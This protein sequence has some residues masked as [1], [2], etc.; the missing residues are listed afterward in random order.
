[1]FTQATGSVTGARFA[2]KKLARKQFWKRAQIRAVK[3]QTTVGARRLRKPRIVFAGVCLSVLC[4]LTGRAQEV[5]A[6]PVE[7]ALATRSFNATQTGFSPDGKWLAY[8]VWEDQRTAAAFSG[9]RAQG[10][11]IYLFSVETGETRH[12]PGPTRASWAPSWSPDAHALAFLSDHD[13][14]TTAWIWDPAK[15]ES[16]ELSDRNVVGTTIEWTTDSRAVLLEVPC[17]DKSRS[18]SVD[19]PRHG[20][21]PEKSSAPTV[22]VYRAAAAAPGKE[23]PQSDPWKLNPALADLVL[24]DVA[25][26]NVHSIVE[27]RGIAMYRLSP[28]GSR[29]AFTSPKRFE[30]PGSQQVI[31]DLIVI[32][33]NGLQERVAAPDIPLDLLGD[34]SWSPDGRQ[35]A[36]ETNG[37]GYLAIDCYVVDAAGGEPRNITLFP[38]M[39]ETS[40]LNNMLRPRWG[41][42]GDCIYLIRNGEFWRAGL[43]GSKPVEVSRIPGH[44]I[45]QFMG[46]SRQLDYLLPASDGSRSAIVV[47]YDDVGKQE[48][49]YKIDLTSGKSTKLLENNQCYYRCTALPGITDPSGKRVAYLSEDARHDFDL[50]MTNADFQSQRRLTHLNPQFDKYKMGSARLIDW[51]DD[52][53]EKLQGALLLPSNYEPGKRY[54]LIVSVY[55]GISQTKYFTQFGFL[56]PGPWNMQLLATRGY[57]VLLPDAPQHVGTPMRDLGKSVLPGVNKLIEMGLADPERLG[58]VGVSYGGY[59]TVSLLVQ[60]TRF[61]AAVEVDGYGDLVGSYGEMDQNGA[62]F[63]VSINEHGQGLMGGPPWEQTMRYI[64]NSPVFFLDRI[65]TPLL[66]VHGSED[67]VVAPFLG[68]ELFVGLR[69]LGKE[70]AYAKYLQEGH[71]PSGFRFANQVDFCNRMIAWFDK[72][73]VAPE[74][75]EA[76]ER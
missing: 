38:A 57:A 34:F 11:E 73:L 72:Y 55:G 30:K 2:S 74:R 54:P 26:G 65:E 4:S 23:V 5:A 9:R 20:L 22:V 18:G 66:I 37:D 56:G 52:D 46:T 32:T 59:S 6:V 39:K 43:S 76:P 40:W 64:E 63:G 61:K 29:V 58:V 28:D 69:R 7:E 31:Y 19:G 16:R 68:D 27:K 71:G 50:W 45:L 44:E 8:T 25:S 41:A 60:T 42:Q 51:L 12:L 1:M 48:G 21:P 15:D 36:F 62:A 33:L 3:L 67:S 13:G 17:S 53:G 14:K 70:V 49:F 35:L 24:V 10:A 75:K 47:T